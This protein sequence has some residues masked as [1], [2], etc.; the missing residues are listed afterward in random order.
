MEVMHPHIDLGHADLQGLREQLASLQQRVAALENER[1]QTHPLAGASA[2][3]SASAPA[4][5]PIDQLLVV[6]SAA[7]AAHMGVKPRIRQIRLLGGA[8]WAQVG[9][10]TIQASHVLHLR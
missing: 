6:I 7:L 9:R 1:A 5:L 10:V 8:S 3:S 4:E 2:G